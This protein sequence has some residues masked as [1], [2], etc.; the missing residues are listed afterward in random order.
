MVKIYTKKGDKGYSNLANTRVK[1]SNAVFLTLGMIDEVSSMLGLCNS[2]SQEIDFTNIQTVLMHI[3]SNLAGYKKKLYLTQETKTLEQEI[4][5]IT[6]KIPP[7]N[8]F[9]LAGGSQAGAT[10]HLTRAKVRLLEQHLLKNK[11]G[12]TQDIFIFFNRLSDYLFTYARYINFLEN[13]SEK[14]LN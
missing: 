9:I 5:E 3:S 14:E 4:D 12:I 8:K 13:K 10:I 11:K 7:L 2:L 1:K 6:S